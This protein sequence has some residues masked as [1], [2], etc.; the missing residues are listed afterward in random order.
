[1]EK[2]KSALLTRLRPHE[3]KLWV[4]LGVPSG[5][6]KAAWVLHAQQHIADDRTISSIPH[7]TLRRADKANP[8]ERPLHRGTQL[9]D[10]DQDRVHVSN[11]Q[12]RRELPLPDCWAVTSSGGHFGWAASEL[13]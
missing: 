11:S 10:A 8:E 6:L 4:S 13:C 3:K 1:M 12:N 2:R 5:I 9:P 7:V